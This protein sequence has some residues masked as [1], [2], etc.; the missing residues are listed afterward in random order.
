MNPTKPID[1]HA[2]MKK[3]LVEIRELRAKL[4]LLERAKSEPIA[5]IG[6]A[7]RFPGA[8][9][10]AAFWDLLARGGDAI[11]EV[12]K[13]RWDAAEYYDPDPDVPGKMYSKWGG[14]L[15]DIDQFSAQ[16]RRIPR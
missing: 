11:R 9:N 12:P 16:S 10:L 1:E 5:I 2:L 15:D 8:A 3:A 4:E 13:E 14:Y 6:M 7:C